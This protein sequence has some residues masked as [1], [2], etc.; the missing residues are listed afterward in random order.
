MWQVRMLG[1]NTI[2][3]RRHPGS[4]SILETD[5]EDGTGLGRMYRFEEVAYFLLLARRSVSERQLC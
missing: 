2:P 5:W 3:K 4:T 1:D